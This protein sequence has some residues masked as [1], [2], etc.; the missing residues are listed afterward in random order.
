MAVKPIVTIPD[1]RL[2]KKTIKVKEFDKEIKE[3]VQN[4]KDTVLSAKEPEGAGLAA[5]QIGSDKRVCIVRNFFLD[6]DNNNLEASEDFILINPK[7][8]S[9]S[10]ETELDFEG[11]LSVPDIYGKVQRYRKIKVKALNETG[12][13][14]RL[15]ASGF[16]SRTI[17]HEI[18]HL[19]GEIF[20]DKVVGNIYTLKELE[21]LEKEKK[22]L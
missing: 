15:S 10:K 9:K 6:P 19:N 12:E 7:I 13:L 4:L 14:I 1:E 3:L 8:I 20:T 17:Q 18:D 21:E 2:Y 22:I 5:P 16:F 11:C